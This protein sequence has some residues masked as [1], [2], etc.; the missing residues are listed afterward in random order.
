MPADALA[1][2]ANHSS[3]SADDAYLRMK[4]DILLCQLPPGSAVTEPALMSRYALGKSSIRIALTR[5]IHEGYVTSRPRKGY[6]VAEIT[7]KDVEE[8]FELRAQL[9]AMSARLAVGRVN[10]EHLRHLEAQCRVAHG[11]TNRS[12]HACQ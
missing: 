7:L 11:R 5:L 8:V 4:R 6:R 3:L 9:E 1:E 10:V 2:W 12:V